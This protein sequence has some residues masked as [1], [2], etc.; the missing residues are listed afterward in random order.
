MALPP[1]TPEQ[2]ID[3]LVKA[4]E[5]R[6]ARAEVK[7]KLKEAKMALSD[8]FVRAETDNTIAKIKVGALLEALPGVG[9]IK[10]QAVMDEIGISDTRRLRG[11]GQ[12]QKDQ[13]VERFG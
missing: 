6:K 5:A 3:A 2:R 4:T 12:H 1:L 13:L 7:L 8:V 11:L 10:A 9:R